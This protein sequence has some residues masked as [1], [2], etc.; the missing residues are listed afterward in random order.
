MHDAIEGRRPNF[1]HEHVALLKRLEQPDFVA[2]A[3]YLS[4]IGR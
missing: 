2:V 4:R 1:P 3:D